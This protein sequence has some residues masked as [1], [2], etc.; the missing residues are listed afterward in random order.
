MTRGRMQRQ[1]K[2]QAERWA[3]QWSLDLVAYAQFKLAD[4]RRVLHCQVDTAPKDLLAELEE[5]VRAYYGSQE[6]KS[7]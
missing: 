5:T 1:T 6:R 4:P 3:E 7:N 2:T